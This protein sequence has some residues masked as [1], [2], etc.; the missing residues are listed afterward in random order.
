[1][2]RCNGIAPPF[3][4]PAVPLVTHDPFFSIWS[5][6]DRLTDGETTHWTGRTHPLTGLV[7]IDGAVHRFCGAEPRHAPMEQVSLALTATATTYT[8]RGGGVRLALSFCS[9]LLCE[10]LAVLSRPATYVCVEV[11]STDGREHEVGVHLDAGA[12]IAVD[13]WD[14]AV[15]WARYDLGAL[16]AVRAGSAEQ[17]PLHR[18]GDDMRIDWGWLYLAAERGQHAT[19]SMGA[20]ETIRDAFAAG[21]GLAER[22][23]RTCRAQPASEHPGARGAPRARARRRA[24]SAAPAHHRL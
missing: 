12:E 20:R 23:P 24:L 19:M 8:F 13:R 2:D 11:E 4:A 21:R 14:Q 1:M 10:D 18:S 17:R 16:E 6:H 15:V 22:R 7:R 3:R 5:Q 9:P